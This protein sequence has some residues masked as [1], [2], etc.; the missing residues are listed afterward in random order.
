MI[1]FAVK[2]GRTPAGPVEASLEGERPGLS[3]SGRI[4]PEIF[5]RRPSV[6]AR[7][8]ARRPVRLASL[9]SELTSQAAAEEADASFDERFGASFDERSD[10]SNAERPREE[11]EAVVFGGPVWP[12][13]FADAL[14]PALGTL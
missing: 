8:P 4:P 14:Q 6:G 3:V 9:E 10:S 11:D 1:G 2:S 13:A 7:I 5:D 12:M